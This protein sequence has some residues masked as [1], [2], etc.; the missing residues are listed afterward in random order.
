MK[1][2]HCSGDEDDAYES[3]SNLLPPTPLSR[4]CCHSPGHHVL[5]SWLIIPF[6]VYRKQVPRRLKAIFH[7]RLMTTK[8]NLYRL[9]P[10][11]VFDAQEIP[12][13]FIYF[14]S[15]FFSFHIHCPRNV[16]VVRQ[17]RIFSY[18]AHRF[19]LL[20]FASPTILQWFLIWSSLFIVVSSFAK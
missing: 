1:F 6:P 11:L 18:C 2:F 17:T 9:W 8:L 5:S 15:P 7:A 19:C 20:T 14:C 4:C 3:G 12:N 16:F 10:W 13:F